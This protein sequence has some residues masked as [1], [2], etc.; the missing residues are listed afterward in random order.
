MKIRLVVYFGIASL[1]AQNIAF[2][3]ESI[4]QIK[5]YS[6]IESAMKS[7]LNIKVR[8][9]AGVGECVFMKPVVVVSP[10][11]AS[12]GLTCEARFFQGGQLKGDWKLLK[13]TLT[14]ENAA[15]EKIA[16]LPS[17]QVDMTIKVEVAG[18]KSLAVSLD[19]ITLSSDAQ[20]CKHWDSAF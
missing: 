12:V 17:S 6:L 4:C 15:F 9:V 13:V 11:K 19:T 3:G 8:R 20:D 7:G 5:G 10:A 18:D 2:A 14:D 16:V 1:M